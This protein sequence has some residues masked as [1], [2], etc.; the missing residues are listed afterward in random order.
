M[1][2]AYVEWLPPNAVQQP[3]KPH[4]HTI[5]VLDA[6]N[7]HGNTSN[8]WFWPYHVT[9]GCAVSTLCPATTVTVATLVTGH[10]SLSRYETSCRKVWVPHVHCH[11]TSQ[12]RC[13]IAPDWCTGIVSRWQ[14]Q[15]GVCTKRCVRLHFHCCL[16]WCIWCCL[17][18][19]GVHCSASAGCHHWLCTEREEASSICSVS[20]GGTAWEPQVH[21][22]EASAFAVVL[23]VLCCRLHG[24]FC[25]V[26]L[27]IMV[28][29]FTSYEE[30]HGSDCSEN[31]P[32]AM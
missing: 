32:F 8:C 12:C 3:L 14:P 11:L 29:F 20:A 9:E 21:G 13:S 30:V 24:T 22:K 25:R 27:C 31:A 28:A 10:T 17:Q 15:G 26:G 1:N 7:L 19:P 5:C 6:A 2:M 16:C 18:G 23:E 4:L